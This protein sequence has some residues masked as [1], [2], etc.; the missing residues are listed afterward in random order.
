MKPYDLLSYQ[1]QIDTLASI[2]D[3]AIKYRALA[4]SGRYDAKT[5]RLLSE[6]ADMVEVKAREFNAAEE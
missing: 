5:S 3:S 1:E 6:L 4:T 2:Q